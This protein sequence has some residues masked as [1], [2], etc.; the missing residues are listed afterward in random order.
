MSYIDE[1]SLKVFLEEIYK[2]PLLT[3]EEERELIRRAKKGDIEA[4]NKL[5][6]SNLRYIYKMAKKYSGM[7]IPISDLINEGVLGLIKAIEKYDLKRRVRLL[8]Y[9]TSWIRQSMMKAL[10]EQS[11]AIKLNSS[12]KSKLDKVRR[13]MEDYYQKYQREPS[14]EELAQITGMSIEE[15][16]EVVNIYKGQFSIDELI[17]DDNGRT[18]EETFPDPF[19]EEIE[20][21]IKKEERINRFMDILEKELNERERKIIVE[22]YGLHMHEPKTLEQIGKELGISRERVRQIKERALRKLKFKYGHLLKA[23]I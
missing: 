13:A 8:T 7:G 20:E 1:Q 5:I 12:I 17:G 19:E 22:Y 2:Y 6:N 4:R 23:I 10:T 14:E 9:A 11:R 15:V 21:K 3:A 18:I 16:K